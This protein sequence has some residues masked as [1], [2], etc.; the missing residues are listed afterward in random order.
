VSDFNNFKPDSAAKVLVR[1]AK[2]LPIVQKIG[3]RLTDRRNEIVE[4]AVGRLDR[5]KQAAEQSKAPRVK[6]ATVWLRYDLDP[7]T[8]QRKTLLGIHTTKQGA[9]LALPE[10]F[11]KLVRKY[12]PDSA[13]V[14]NYLNK[15]L[16]ARTVED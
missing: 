4:D 1:E 14:Q 3:Q 7:K 15:A 6:A 2:E 8:K 5:D 9:Q 11:Q 12:P 16:E 13:Y 10:E